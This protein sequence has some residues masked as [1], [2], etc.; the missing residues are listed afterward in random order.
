MLVKRSVR[1]S[2]HA[3]SLALEPEFW[4]ALASLAETWGL[5]IDQAV[6]RIDADRED[7][8]GNLTSAIRVQVLDHYRRL[9]DQA[10]P[11]P[12]ESEGG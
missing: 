12:E 1:L 6:A 7:P 2:G 10:Q 9:A 11:P 5:G 4:E 8:S 3:T